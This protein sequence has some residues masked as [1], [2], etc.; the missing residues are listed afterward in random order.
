L[1]GDPLSLSPDELWLD[2]WAIE[3]GLLPIGEIGGELLNGVDLRGCPG[4]DAW[5]LLARPR[6]ASRSMEELRRRTLNLLALGETDAAVAAAG[7]AAR[8]DLLNEDAQDLFLRTLVAAGHE[9][10]ASIHLASCELTFAREGLV[11]SSRCEPP[12]RRHDR[13]RA[14]APA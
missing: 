7:Q 4:F 1:R 13:C 6:W 12:P 11:P 2:V 5:L 8:L 9:G 10:L 14:Y 3:D